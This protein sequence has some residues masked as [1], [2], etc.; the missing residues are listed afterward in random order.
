[1]SGEFSF[2]GLSQESIWIS[3]T[4]TND[5]NIKG[6]TVLQ[7]VDSSPRLDGPPLVVLNLAPAE[8]EVALLV[9]QLGGCTAKDVERRLGKRVTNA[10]VR[11]MLRRLMKKG[12]LT[13]RSAGHYKTF[14]YVPAITNEFVRQSAIIHL[15]QQHF[16]GSLPRLAAT[17][18]ELL[19]VRS[20]A[21]RTEVAAR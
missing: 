4:R 6:S 20:A 10:T 1:M 3:T 7:L 17:L 8:R 5:L 2:T 14:I 16:A 13:R 12:I 11:T 19:N 18:D 21:A 15:A 9:Y